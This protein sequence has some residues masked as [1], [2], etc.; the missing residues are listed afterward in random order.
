MW[1]RSFLNNRSNIAN[2]NSRN[3]MASFGDDCPVK[4]NRRVA[5]ITGSTSGIGL[6]C[7]K[8]LAERDVDIILT[9]FGEES[10]IEDIKKDISR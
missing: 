7:A 3:S 9:G 4:S 10:L 6:A 5:L 8:A 2:R 1:G